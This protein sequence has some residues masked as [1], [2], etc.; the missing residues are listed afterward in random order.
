MLI[1]IRKYWNNLIE[2]VKNIYTT[3][4][5]ETVYKNLFVN[6]LRRNKKKREKILQPSSSQQG[7]LPQSTPNNWTFE[8][9]KILSLCQYSLVST[10]DDFFFFPALKQKCTH[11]NFYHLKKLVRT[12]QTMSLEYQLK[13][14]ANVFRI[15]L[16][17]HKN[18]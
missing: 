1:N 5:Q 4:L 2:D 13:R 11:S 10:H 3:F 8:R 15:L 7:L 12:F 14:G 6:S 18:V 17:P 9:E 16:N